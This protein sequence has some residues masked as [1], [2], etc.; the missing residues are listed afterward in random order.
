MLESGDERRMTMPEYIVSGPL[1][2]E[3]A[4]LKRTIKCGNSD[5]LTGYICALSVV[6][7][8]ITEQ[9]VADV[10]PMKHGRWITS[11]ITTDSGYTSC[12][13][14][15]SEYYIGDLQNLEGDNDFVMYCPNCGARMDG[16]QNI[17][18]CIC[19]GEIIPEGRQ[20]CPKCENK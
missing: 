17:E 11:E 13:C 7:E 20:V 15:H 2:K 12:S 1:K 9:P 19:C 16:A 6:E 4:D 10:Q 14:C 8:M 3:I 18:T 5:Y